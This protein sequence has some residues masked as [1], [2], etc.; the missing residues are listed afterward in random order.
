MWHLPFE[1]SLELILC[2][3]NLLSMKL[4]FILEVPSISSQ[5]PIVVKNKYS[6]YAP[7]RHEY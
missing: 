7:C 5:M 1:F 6:P 4:L 3:T 2:T